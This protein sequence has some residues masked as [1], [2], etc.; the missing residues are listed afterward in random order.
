M[1]TGRSARSP[2][3]FFV[4]TLAFCA[5]FWILGTVVDRPGG[6]PMDL[7]WAALSV[8][9]PAA[10]ALLLVRRAEGSR[11]VRELLRRTVDHRRIAAR[12][13]LPVLL[14]MPAVVG[15][16]TVLGHVLGVAPIGTYSPF[17]AVPVLAVA[18]FVGAWCEEVGWTAYATDPMRARWGW[19]RAAALLG[20]MWV[21]IHLVPWIQVRGL[22]WAGGYA[23]FTVA[24]RV[25]MVGL[26]RGTGGSVFAVILF[27]TVIN[28]S[29][30]LSPYTG[31]PQIPYLWT[32]ITVLLA[33]AAVPLWRAAAPARP[34]GQPPGSL[35]SVRSPAED[36]AISGASGPDAGNR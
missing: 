12:W 35:T 7:P 25:V 3:A 1:T 5:P 22:L 15:L 19:W 23:L 34:A 32:A 2:L 30:S 13:Y 24:A 4:L 18:Y 27:H 14:F 8:V 6:V 21:A 17:S 9:A 20:L 29:G 28:T 11:G 26:Y 36:A 31:S 10:A 16:S 33:A